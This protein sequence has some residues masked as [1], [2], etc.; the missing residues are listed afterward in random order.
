M[1]GHRLSEQHNHLPTLFTIK[2]PFADKGVTLCWTLER[3]KAEGT[4]SLSSRHP[5]SKKF[6]VFVLKP[7]TFIFFTSF[8]CFLKLILYILHLLVDPKNFYFIF[9]K[10]EALEAHLAIDDMD[11]PIWIP[12]FWFP[13]EKS[14]ILNYDE[15]N[16]I[17]YFWFF[18]LHSRLHNR[19]RRW[20]K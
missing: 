19:I 20:L 1:W 11:I 8:T 14:T 17:K 10:F 3:I 5:L 13:R 7:Q 9:Q 12:I 2:L 16:M 15:R 18:L 6:I 4:S